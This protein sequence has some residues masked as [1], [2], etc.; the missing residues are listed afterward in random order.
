M[1]LS[2]NEVLV[3]LREHHERDLTTMQLRCLGALVLGYDDETAGELFGIA[4]ST[5]RRHVGNAAARILDPLDLPSTRQLLTTWFWLHTAACTAGVL[6]MIDHLQTYAWTGYNGP[7]L[8]GC[9]TPWAI[10]GRLGSTSSR[11]EP[12]PPSIRICGG[13]QSV[14]HYRFGCQRLRRRPRT[15]GSRARC[16][17]NTHSCGANGIYR[18]PLTDARRR[19]P[20]GL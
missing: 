16:I 11:H 4:G 15:T 17:S 18:N 19:W 9:G 13:R 7:A 5:F 8:D 1:P 10:K 20:R 2:P 6:E 3:L 14:V 12:E